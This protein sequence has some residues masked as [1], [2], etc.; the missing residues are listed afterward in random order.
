MEWRKAVRRGTT[1]GKNVSV[2]YS[3]DI[4]REKSETDMQADVKPR[5][6]AQIARHTVKARGC[7]GMGME[8]YT[9]RQR[10]GFQQT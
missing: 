1:K 9:H 6:A 5:M 3:P 10:A 7:K 2:S 8:A 4:K